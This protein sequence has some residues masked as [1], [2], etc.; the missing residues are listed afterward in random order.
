MALF[1]YFILILWSAGSELI[2][3]YSSNYDVNDTIAFIKKHIG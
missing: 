3:V 2:K 1:L